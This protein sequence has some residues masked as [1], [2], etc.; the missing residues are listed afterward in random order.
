M[1][2]PFLLMNEQQRAEMTGNSSQ[3]SYLNTK[4]QNFD[5]CP[6][7]KSRFASLIASEEAATRDTMKD[8]SDLQ[9]AVYLGTTIKPE[10]LK[11]MQFRQYMSI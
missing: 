1:K 10:T 8:T 7:A 3:L 2:L 5:V 6:E 11:F 4:T 9:A